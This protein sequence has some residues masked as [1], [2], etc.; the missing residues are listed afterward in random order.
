MNEEFSMCG[1]NLRSAS[2]IILAM[3]FLFCSFAISA[4]EFYGYDCT[5]DCSGHMAGYEWAEENGITDP[6][7]CGGNSNS[8]IEGCIAYAEEY[9]DYYGDN[10]N[11]TEYGEPCEDYPEECEEEQNGY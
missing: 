3:L 7:H 9:Q 1:L 8:F 6:D 4:Q 2:K 11:L 5:D 10:E